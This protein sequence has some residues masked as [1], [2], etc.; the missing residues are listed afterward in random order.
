MADFR[1][2]TLDLGVIEQ[3]RAD[4]RKP[5]KYIAAELGAS[6]ATITARIRALGE[7]RVMRVLAQRNMGR[8]NERIACFVEVSVRGRSTELGAVT[9]SS[10]LELRGRVRR[11]G[12]SG[13]GGARSASEA[14]GDPHGG[15]PQ[16]CLGDDPR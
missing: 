16:Q 1:P 13:R 10:M 9:A 15:D 14:T 6:E 3:L 7:N 2:D 12:G 5:A 11:H 4:G 8:L